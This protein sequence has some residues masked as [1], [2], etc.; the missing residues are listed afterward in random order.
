[1]YVYYNSNNNLIKIFKCEKHYT[2]TLSYYLNKY[3]LFIYTSTIPF[4]KPQQ[5]CNNNNNTR[6]F[7]SKTPTTTLNINTSIIIL[8]PISHSLQTPINQFH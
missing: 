7:N 1:M 5:I 2:I 6:T 4:H 8:N 3:L